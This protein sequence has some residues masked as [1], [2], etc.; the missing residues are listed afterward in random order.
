[1]PTSTSSLLP[2]LLL[3]IIG[4][5]HASSRPTPF[6]VVA[7]LPE[8]RYE[9][10]NFDWLASRTS[11]VILFSLE[12][13]ANGSI[14]ALDRLPRRAL[15]DEAREAASR[16]DTQLMV[17]FGGNGRSSGFSRMTRDP[18]SRARFVSEVESL[19]TA[20]G[21]DGVD[22]NWE[23]PGYSFGR[24]YAAPAEVS[25]EYDGLLALLRDLRAVLAP[26]GRQLTAAYYPDGRQERLFA[27]HGAGGAGILQ[28]VDLL[29]A[30]AYDASEPDGQHSSLRLA[31]AVLE[32][33]RRERVLH[34][35]TLGVPFYARHV[36]TGAWTS[37]ED[38][39]LRGLVASP[40]EDTASEPRGDGGGGG[41]MV[42][43]NG[44]RTI[45]TKVE[46]ALQA[47]AR[48]VMIWEGGQDCRVRA[49]GPRD[50]GRVHVRTC[51]GSG[52]EWSLLA[53]INRT[54]ERTKPEHRVGAGNG[55][56]PG[57]DSDDHHA[58]GDTGESCASE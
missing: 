25:R 18:A 13:M 1:M 45:E 50:D 5:S 10:C 39:L 6:A 44:V 31:R 53:A 51:P 46:L 37:Y 14:A 47:G 56:L 49:V 12:P 36:R 11:H 20:H 23:Y 41:G 9:G 8:W 38:L 40:E 17:C 55:Q 16:H 35:L 43:F 30:M 26:A 29:H 57:D 54:I 58:D 48:G 22:I 2:R 21:L 28:Y 34:K 19:L 4:A 15:L 3:V 42:A 24:G 33:A 52:D 7:Y 27:T 32:Q